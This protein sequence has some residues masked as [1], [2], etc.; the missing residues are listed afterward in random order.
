MAK[1]FICIG[2]PRAGQ[3]LNTR[4]GCELIR[5]PV[6]PAHHPYDT[7]DITYQ[8]FEYREH[9]FMVNLETRE[10]ITVW[11]PAGQTL[12]QVIELLLESYEKHRRTQ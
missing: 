9:T 2:G 5:V 1:S 8:V 3:R 7:P 6:R 12:K 4:D 11:G 10:C